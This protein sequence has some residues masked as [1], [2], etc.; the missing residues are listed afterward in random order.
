[1]VTTV[2]SILKAKGR[3]VWSVSP[4]ASVYEAARLMADRN[5]GAVLVESDGRVVGVLSERDYVSRLILPG[6]DAREVRVSEVMTSPVMVVTQ[7]HTVEECMRL[8]TK[9]RVR[10]LPVVDGDDENV[11]G[12]VSIGDLVNSIIN[13]QGEI[14]QQLE[15]YITGR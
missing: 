10:H 14:I 15:S 9:R 4:A 5:V 13:N 6:R 7:S 2:A 12:V 11:V 3:Q 8:M 1:M